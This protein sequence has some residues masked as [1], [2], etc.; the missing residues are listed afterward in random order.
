MDPQTLIELLGDQSFDSG[1]EKLLNKLVGAVSPLSLSQV[2]AVV[3]SYSYDD[4]RIKAVNILANGKK[5]PQNSGAP[6]VMID[7][8][9]HM[10]YDPGRTA[11]LRALVNTVSSFSLDHLNAIV[12]SYSY[13]D[14]RVEAVNILANNQKLSKH[15]GSPQ[16]MIDLMG[17]MSYDPGRT[18]VLKALVSIYPKVTLSELNSIM[19]GYSYDEGK[20]HAFNFFYQKDQVTQIERKSILEGLGGLSYDKARFTYLSCLR[21][22]YG[23][24]DSEEKFT[25]LLDA[26]SYEKDKVLRMVADQVKLEKDALCR[27]MS[28]NMKG[29]EAFVALC[30]EF[31]IPEESIEKYKKNAENTAT[32]S[33]G[34]ASFKMG[35]NSQSFIEMG[36]YPPGSVVTIN[37]VTFKF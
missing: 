30:K 16:L 15:G 14:G 24:I 4:G 18:S 3:Q 34:G 32:I 33:I 37:G 17:H 22:G 36:H 13:D 12:Q 2:S 27:I 25:A 5:L 6:L 8:M 11:V 9:G 1:R 28:L 23:E 31:Q 29:V 20:I 10:S 7:L 21:K 19:G 35:G 26:F